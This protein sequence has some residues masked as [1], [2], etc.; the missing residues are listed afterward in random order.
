M[1]DSIPPEVGAIGWTDLTV[2]DADGLRDFYSSV[3]GW[4]HSP[5][6]M[7]GYADYCMLTPSTGRTVAGVCHAR[8]V[9]AELP[10]V[11]LVYI[12]VE[13]LDRSIDR[14]REL[15]GTILIG[16][17][18]MAGNDRYCVIKDPAGAV[19]ALYQ[20]GAKKKGV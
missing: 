5:V 1:A 11:W 2:P 10:P 20:P 18:G 16:P 19:A 4:T 8:G 14:C 3:V 9:N 12:T 6:D 13:D 7:G 17:K 15:G